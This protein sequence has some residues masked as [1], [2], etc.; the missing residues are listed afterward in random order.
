M[1][2][3]TFDRSSAGSTILKDCEAIFKLMT[4]SKQ[5]AN[6]LPL[7]IGHSAE[8]AAFAPQVGATY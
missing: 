5:P 1:G 6:S 8:H 7:D 2:V 3:N 4:A